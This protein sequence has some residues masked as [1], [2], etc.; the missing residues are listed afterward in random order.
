VVEKD[1]EAFSIR[2]LEFFNCPLSFLISK[3]CYYDV[4]TEDSED[5]KSLIYLASS[6]TLVTILLIEE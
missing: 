5:F 6:I 3:P 4:I 2:A 1:P